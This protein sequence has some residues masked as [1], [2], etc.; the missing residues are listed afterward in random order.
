MSLAALLGSLHALTAAVAAS[1]GNGALAGPAD[2][3]LFLDRGALV[4]APPGPVREQ[5]YL[6]RATARKHLYRG[7]ISGARRVTP[8]TSRV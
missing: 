6:T 3:G 7:P 8:N 4:G 1:F 2:G 5:A